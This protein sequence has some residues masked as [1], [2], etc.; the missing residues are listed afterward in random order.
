MFADLKG[1]NLALMT[2]IF[3]A[4]RNAFERDLPPSARGLQRQFV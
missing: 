4:V 2:V 1:M 3:G